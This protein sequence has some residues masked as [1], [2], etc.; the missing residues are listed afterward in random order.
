MKNQITVR[1][2]GTTERMNKQTY[3]QSNDRLIKRMNEQTNRRDTN[4]RS[5]EQ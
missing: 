3:E 2:I 1:T 5:N 4:H